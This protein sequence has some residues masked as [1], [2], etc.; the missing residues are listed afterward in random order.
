MRVIHTFG[1]LALGATL[2]G[3][4]MGFNEE[5]QLRESVL[6]IIHYM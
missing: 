2:I 1:L 4:L 5:L 6:K 3:I